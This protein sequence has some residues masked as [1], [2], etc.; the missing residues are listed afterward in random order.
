MTTLIDHIASWDEARRLP[1]IPFVSSDGIATESQPE[2]DPAWEA[3]I[4]ALL[5]LWDDPSRLAN[6]GEPPNRR[7]IEAAIA[8]IAFLRGRFPA[9]PPTCIAPEPGGGII[10]ER[11][12]RSASGH[13]W[14]CELTLSND[15]T[16][17]RTDYLDGRILQMN[18]LPG[19]PPVPVA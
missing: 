6:N 18:M 5:E 13:D 12:V 10:L 14:L 7:A 3:C 15:G 8:W 9:A 2:E 11:R 4:D 19:H 17:E 16:A 1:E